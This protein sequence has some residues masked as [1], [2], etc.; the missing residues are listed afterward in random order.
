MP[1]QRIVM[2][3]GMTKTFRENASAAEIRDAVESMKQRMAVDRHPAPNASLAGSVTVTQAAPKP[4]AA[5]TGVPALPSGQDINSNIAQME[6]LRART[7]TSPWNFL[8]PL[9]G[10]TTLGQNW[11]DRLS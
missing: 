6:R 4:S 7:E 8:I 5:D 10:L 11:D 3:D 2:P 1:V 9:Y